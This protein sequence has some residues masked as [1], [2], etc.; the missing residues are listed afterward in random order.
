M[1]EK[2]K[3]ENISGIGEVVYKKNAHAKYYRIRINM[4]GQIFVTVP[5]LGTWKNAT[6][7]VVNNKQWIIDHVAN[8]LSKNINPDD[9][10]DKKLLVEKALQYIPL[11]LHQLANQ[12]N[13]HYLNLKFNHARTR[14][15][16]CNVHNGI[17]ISVYI[18]KLPTHLIDFILL[19][20]LTH[21]LYK[22][23]QKEFHEKLN[24]LCAGKEKQ[25]VKEI[26]DF[27]KKNGI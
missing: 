23:H 13:L 9:C 26:R 16:S 19:H 20:E 7:F 5:Y 18:M 14:W 24:E 12:H 10:V 22:N 27:L 3:V 11:R 6:Q 2:E 1:F 25:Y 4:Y 8:R 17:N 21:T 15:G